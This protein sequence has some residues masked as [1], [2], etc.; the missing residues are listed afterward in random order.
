MAAGVK[1]TSTCRAAQRLD[2]HPVEPEVAA[3]AKLLDADH[4]TLVPFRRL[5][6]V[7]PQEPVPPG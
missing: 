6:N 4:H 1:R 3:R 2:Q 7:S 5:R